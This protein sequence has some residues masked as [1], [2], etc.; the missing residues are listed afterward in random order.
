ML[1]GC[2]QNEVG[3]IEFEY[4]SLQTEQQKETTGAEITVIDTLPEVD[5]T[6]P[7]ELAPLPSS[8][9][10]NIMG[11][12]EAQQRI[13]QEDKG[14]ALLTILPEGTFTDEESIYDYMEQY[15]EERQITWD[16]QDVYGR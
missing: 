12:E 11:H 13:S 1:C 8:E 15:A 7:R 3:T 9:I 4:I 10:I 6:I 14:E 5:E 2:S 16:C